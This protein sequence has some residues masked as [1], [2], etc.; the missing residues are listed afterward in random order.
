MKKGRVR[1]MLVFQLLGRLR[2]EDHLSQELTANLGNLVRSCFK[3]AKLKNNNNK[4]TGGRV[5]A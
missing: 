3:T 1:H 4:A 5:P 2:E